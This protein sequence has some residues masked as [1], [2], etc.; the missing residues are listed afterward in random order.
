MFSYIFM[1]ILE[2]R[3]HRYDSGINLLTGGHAAKIRESIVSNFVRPDMAVLDVGCGTGDLAVKAAKKGAFVTGVDIS[4]GML[5]IAR[6]RAKKNNIEDKIFF[7]QAGVV[8]MDRLF[9]ENNFD[10]IVSTLVISELYS[11]ERK[12]TMR[13][14]YRI[15]KPDG[16]LVVAGEVRPQNLVKRILYYTLRIPLAIVT[17][18]ISQSGTRPV[19]NISD[20]LRTA[21][22]EITDERYSFLG[23]FATIVARKFKAPSPLAAAPVMKP[24]YDIS[25]IKSLFDY[26]GRWFPNPVEPG[27]RIIGTP[28][29]HAPVIVT[30]NY[31]LTVRR[32]E[33][34]LENQSCYLLVAQSGG[35]NV[36]CASAGREMNTHA[37]IAVLKTS[38]VCEYVNHRA[39]ILPQLAASAINLKKL[40]KATGWDGVW[41]PVHAAELP[42]FFANDN[43]KNR[44]QCR[45]RFPFSFRMELLL[46][47]NCILWF[48]FFAFSLAIN[49]AWALVVTVVFWSAGFILYAGYY[50]LPFRSGWLK[51]LALSVVVM[52]IVGWISDYIGGNLQ[53]HVGWM[54]FTFLIILSIGFD[55]KGIVGDQTSEAEALIHRLGF[56]SFGDLFTSTAVHDGFISQ[57]RSRCSNCGMCCTVCPMGVFNALENQKEVKILDDSRCLKCKACVMQCPETALSLR[58]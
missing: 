43:T 51:A 54:V 5:A 40:R 8:D 46:S 36:W 38:G 41:G 11:E 34:A 10:F 17:Y 16:K 39:L 3:P 55:L 57:D 15:L 14:L 21:G 6:A 33:K 19:R 35:I 26:C 12:W 20:E 25:A 29:R 9:D 47:M 32:V 53:H 22:F 4:E 58:K 37:I 30:G 13:E 1:K 42:A 27:L 48:V 56:N 23:S 28:G 18:L 50:Y 52:A 44:E 49:P 24:K 31:H 2:T 45:A 7:H